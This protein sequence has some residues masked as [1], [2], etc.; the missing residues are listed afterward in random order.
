MLNG[1]KFAGSY[2]SPVLLP[3]KTHAES[4]PLTQ[5]EVL[6]RRVRVQGKFLGI[7]K[8][9]RRANKDGIGSTLMA[10]TGEGIQLVMSAIQRKPNGVFAYTPL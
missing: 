3:L 7:I 1:V 2:E 4:K 10:I 5:G 9:P 8:V 6:G